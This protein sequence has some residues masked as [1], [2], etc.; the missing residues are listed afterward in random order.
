VARRALAYSCDRCE[1]DEFLALKRSDT[2]ESPTSQEMILNLLCQQQKKEKKMP[3]DA[4]FENLVSIFC[5]HLAS[6]TILLFDD[7]ELSES[8][9]SFVDKL[10]RRKENIRILMTSR[11]HPINTL[12]FPTV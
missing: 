8:L 5:E 3:P 7:F 9:A 4:S 6:R 2:I 10:H 11:D 12:K 1:F